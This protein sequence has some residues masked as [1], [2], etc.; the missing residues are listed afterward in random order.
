MSIFDFA[1]ALWGK[2]IYLANEA[3]SFLR[4]DRREVGMFGLLIRF[5]GDPGGF[6]QNRYPVN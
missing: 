4:A 3:R 6:G 1:G 2:R 5:L